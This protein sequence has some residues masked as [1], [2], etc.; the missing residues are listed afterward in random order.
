MFSNWQ[1]WEYLSL[2]FLICIWMTGWKEGGKENTFEYLLYSKH[3]KKP[4]SPVFLLSTL[5]SDLYF[6]SENCYC[7]ER[8]SILFIYLVSQRTRDRF[9]PWLLRSE[10]LHHSSP[11]FV[12]TC[13]G[14]T[15]PA[16]AFLRPSQLQ[17]W[18]SSLYWFRTTLRSSPG[19]LLASSLLE[20][21]GIIPS[22]T[23]HQQC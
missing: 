17:T 19:N 16:L 23:E 4:L 21:A 13:R 3:L 8:W 10:P 9:Q 6:T 20:E 7:L 11:W 18:M 2:S 12:F 5:K 15:W 22:I 14:I 1:I